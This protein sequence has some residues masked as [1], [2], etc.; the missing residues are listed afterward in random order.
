M[1]PAVWLSFVADVVVIVIKIDLKVMEKKSKISV[2][3]A[4]C[5]PA[6]RSTWGH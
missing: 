4:Y 1:G 2:Y 3:S 6:E 5:Q